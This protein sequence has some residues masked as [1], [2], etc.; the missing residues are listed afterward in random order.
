MPSKIVISGDRADVQVDTVLVELDKGHIL[1]LARQLPT[2]ELH[3]LHIMIGRHL[4]GEG[5][6]VEVT[7]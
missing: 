3:W 4:D 7:A 1:E 5:A 2:T 6:E